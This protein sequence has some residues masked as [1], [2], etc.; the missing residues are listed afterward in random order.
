ML[1]HD[2]RS[3]TYCVTAM[4]LNNTGNLGLS[5]TYMPAQVTQKQCKLNVIVQYAFMRDVIFIFIF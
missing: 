2:L 3:L 5:I 4:D 1:L